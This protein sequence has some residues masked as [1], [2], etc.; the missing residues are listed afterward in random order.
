MSFQ[1]L[2]FSFPTIFAISDVKQKKWEERFLT[3]IE[4]T[5]MNVLFIPDSFHL[6]LPLSSRLQI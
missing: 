3:I 1:R 6:S 2:Q 4:Q 5:L